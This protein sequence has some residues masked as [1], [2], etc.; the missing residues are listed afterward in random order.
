MTASSRADFEKEAA[1]S[2]HLR[3]SLSWRRSTYSGGTNCVEVATAEGTVYI[4]DSK[5]TDSGHVV[6]V[7]LSSWRSL[8]NSIRAG[9]L[10]L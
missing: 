9:E 1:A 5:S 10:N 7:P 2:L 6:T 8:L 3:N 4:R